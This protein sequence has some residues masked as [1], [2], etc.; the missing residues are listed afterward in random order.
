MV[1]REKP[2]PADLLTS[3]RVSAVQWVGC[4]ENT[5]EP[6][7][8]RA[9]VIRRLFVRKRDSIFI[10]TFGLVYIVTQEKSDIQTKSFWRLYDPIPRGPCFR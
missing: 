5:N 1:A 8:K 6:K 2:C 4:V 10:F 3:N 7:A 9:F